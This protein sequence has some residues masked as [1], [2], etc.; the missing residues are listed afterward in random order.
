MAG[1][2]TRQKEEL[3]IAIHEY[4]VRNHFTSAAEHFAAEAKVNSDQINGGTSVSSRE[5]LLEKK[6]TSL[7]KLKMEAD[8][9]AK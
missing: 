1:L 7:A 2:T 5:N 3:N 9:L 6:W 8:E 4:L